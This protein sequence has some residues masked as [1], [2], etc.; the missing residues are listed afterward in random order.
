M[1]LEDRGAE[2]RP[3]DRKSAARFVRRSSSGRLN[4]DL[5]RP[6][7]GGPP[8]PRPVRS[9][10]RFRAPAKRTLSERSEASDR[11]ASGASQYPRLRAMRS[12]EFGGLVAS[13]AGAA[14]TFA[15]V[16]EDHDDAMKAFDRLAEHL[17]R[18]GVD[19][20]CHRCGRDEWAPLSAQAFL[21]DVDFPT[22]GGTAAVT[23]VCSCCG[24]IELFNP[25]FAA[26][27]PHQRRAPGGR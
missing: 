22:A 20:R 11:D 24:L 19:T 25:G 2:P 13:P 17:A 23:R 15:S 14:G 9:Q 3:V 6:G 4:G 8:R 10:A 26:T 5:G 16:P 7:S 12:G 27:T 18:K 21:P 1:L